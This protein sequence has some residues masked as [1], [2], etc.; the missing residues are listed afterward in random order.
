MGVGIEYRSDNAGGRI[1]GLYIE[2]YG[3]QQTSLDINYHANRIL[4]P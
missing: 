2:D 3:V 4:R 1:W